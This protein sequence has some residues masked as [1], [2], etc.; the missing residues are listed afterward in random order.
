MAREL[1]FVSTSRCGSSARSCAV[2]VR[3]RPT[4]LWSVSAR[5][6]PRPLPDTA[7]R[8]S[9]PSSSAT[10][11]S[12][13][14]RKAKWS[15]ASQRSRSTPRSTSRASTVDG[16]ADSTS[17]MISRSRL[18]IRG[19]SSTASRM[20]RRTPSNCCSIARASSSSAT[21]S[22]SRWIH[23]SCRVARPE[24]STV[25]ASALPP[26][27]A[28]RTSRSSPARSR[29]TSNCG[30]I[31]TWMP[32]PSRVSAIEVESTRNGMS[33]VTIS[34]TLRPPADQPWS[35]VVGVKTRTPR[36][37]VRDAGRRTSWCEA[38]APWTSWG[39]RLTRSPGATCRKYVAS[40]AGTSSGGGPSA[41]APLIATSTAC[42]R[43]PALVSSGRS[44][45][46]RP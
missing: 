19:Q 26:S 40:S 45:T 16:G 18:C 12:R 22:I 9:S 32:W 24:S 36:G 5:R 21:R 13:K 23:D 28:I 43:S 15:S 3:G 38:N 25:W 37:A 8:T 4:L 10:S 17:S 42:A 27:V 20:S 41:P 34:T 39:V 11:Y 29:R 7:C 30:W 33:S 6:M 44:A 1:A 14:P 46:V 31:T 35:A 2:P